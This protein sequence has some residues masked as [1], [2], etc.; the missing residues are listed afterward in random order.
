MI[1]TIIL[2]IAFVAQEK[3]W[4]E[5]AVN[6]QHIFNEVVLY[7]AYIFLISFN[8]TGDANARVK[9]GY[10]LI[11]LAVAFMIVNFMVIS[12]ITLIQFKLFWKKTRNQ[13]SGVK[14][15]PEPN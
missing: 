13:K 8:L 5:S 10:G 3:P 9:F 15:V 14:V 1:L 2:N 6:K 12:R 7:F 11:Y 4:T